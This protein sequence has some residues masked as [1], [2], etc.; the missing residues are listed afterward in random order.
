MSDVVAGLSEVL[1]GSVGL[2]CVPGAFGAYHA[3]RGYEK[4]NTISYHTLR[5]KRH[6]KEGNVPGSY[7]TRRYND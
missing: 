4:Y 6:K 5:A 7:P 3:R 2:R 1:L